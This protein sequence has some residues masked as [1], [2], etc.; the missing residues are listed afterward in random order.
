MI[1]GIFGAK[2]QLVDVRIRD[3]IKIST[4]EIKYA[5]QYIEEN[6]KIPVI[7]GLSNMSIQDRINLS[8]EKDALDFKNI[9]EKQSKDGFEE[10]KS[11]G[12]PFHAYQAYIEYKVTYNKDNLLSIP[13]TYY[14]YIG[15]AHGITNIIS[16][17]INLKIGKD[18][19]IKDMFKEGV[20]YK[21][22]IKQE[23]I[24]QIKL[25]P[26]IYFEDAIKTVEGSNE[27]FSFYIEDGNIVVYYSLYSIAPY[28]SG[29]REFKIPFEVFKD[30]I[31]PEYK[32]SS[33]L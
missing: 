10:A 20:N 29:I 4:K 2:A 31:N 28:S 8:F 12:Y 23:V 18:I 21:D 24:K 17:N 11:A 33:N 1:S 16:R 27:K 9:I 15:G 26:E 3:K 32:Q 25:Q 14:S 5:D 7:E 22:I 19:A 6:I 30:G 13:V